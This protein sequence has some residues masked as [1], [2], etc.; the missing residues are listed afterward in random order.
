[1]ANC[2]IVDDSRLSREMIREIVTEESHTVAGEGCDGLEAVRLYEELQPDFV[3]MDLEMPN[4]TG[5]EAAEQI[6]RQYPDA[7]I[8]LVTSI[9][10]KREIN[11]AMKRG[12]KAAISKP[13]DEKELKK[14]LKNIM[15]GAA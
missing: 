15:G 1:M 11:I 2:L 12:V 7:K 8:I 10:N 9:V 3:T 14:V 5:L 6:L 4:L 13:I